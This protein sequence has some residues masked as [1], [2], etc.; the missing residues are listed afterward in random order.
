MLTAIATSHHR[1]VR[2]R[3]AGKVETK[4]VPISDHAIVRVPTARDRARASRDESC[5][6][7]AGSGVVER[8][9]E[10]WVAQR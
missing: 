10:R 9:S 4:K 2:Y 6:T 3:A 1:R 7:T 8:I 5:E